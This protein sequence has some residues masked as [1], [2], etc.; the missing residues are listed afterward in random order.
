VW[1]RLPLRGRRESKHLHPTGK[2][3]LSLVPARTEALTG[4]S[5]GCLG[6]IQS[7]GQS[8]TGELSILSQ[9]DDEFG[10]VPVLGSLE[11]DPYT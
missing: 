5:V 4:V 7:P 10:D 6:Q 9:E 1:D 2:P 3:K 8:T 11:A